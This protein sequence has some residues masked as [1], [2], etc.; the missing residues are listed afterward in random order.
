MITQ[1]DVMIAKKIAIEDFDLFCRIAGVDLLQLKACMLRAKGLS[2]AQISIKMGMP[3]S[4]IKYK[5][6]NC[7]NILHA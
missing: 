4:T 6:S 1:E 7:A 2:L 5:S 3:K